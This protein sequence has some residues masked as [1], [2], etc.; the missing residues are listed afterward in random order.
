MEARTSSLPPVD[1]GIGGAF[2]TPCPGG[3][4]GG[5]GPPA[6]GIGGG[7][8]GGGGPPVDD[9]AVG[10]GREADGRG[11]G[12]GGCG[13]LARFGIGG[14]GGGCDTLAP[15]GIGGGG[16]G[17]EDGADA[18][19]VF[20]GRGGGVVPVA[21]T[22]WW[23]RVSAEKVCPADVRLGGGGGI[24]DEVLS[25]LKGG[26]T[27]NFG[28]VSEGSSIGVLGGRGGGGGPGFPAADAA[29]GLEGGAG[30]LKLA[31]LPASASGGGALNLGGGG[32]RGGEES[33]AGASDG[34][35]SCVDENWLT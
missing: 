18:F 22:A 27:A 25:L 2:A 5:G 12:G 13:T 14:G 28:L 31:N 10:T 8:G 7:G 26:G 3:K 20:G 17:P 1:F 9:G 30:P 24:A 23:L 11:G 4:G 34:L 19:G 35:S 29:R 33:R 32:P 6:A 15:F 16:G 21:V